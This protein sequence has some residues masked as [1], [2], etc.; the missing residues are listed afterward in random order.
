[1]KKYRKG[2]TLIEL[3]VVVAII[4]IL[5][6]IVISNLGESR[7]RAKDA[8]I[9][10]EM[11][12]LATAVEIETNALGDYTNVCD[13]FGIGGDLEYIKQSIEDDG[14]IWESCD[15]DVTSYAVIVTLNAQQAYNLF[16]AEEAYARGSTT[17]CHAPGT[18]EQETLEVDDGDLNLHMLHDDDYGPCQPLGGSGTFDGVHSDDGLLL[19]SDDIKALREEARSNGDE[20]IEPR[21]YCIGAATASTATRD[22]VRKGYLYAIPQGGCG[23]PAPT[24]ESAQDAYDNRE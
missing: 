13:L 7:T 9:V 6:T 22:G 19:T 2:F 3:L 17:I 18:P 16:Y 1:M 12:Q 11:N 10:T 5:A 23:S 8:A 4:G 21:Y 24:F 20:F 15:S 14:G